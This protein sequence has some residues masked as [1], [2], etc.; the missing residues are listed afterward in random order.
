MSINDQ[1]E[2][3]ISI[4]TIKN[5]NIFGGKDTNNTGSLM[6]GEFLDQEIEIEVKWTNYPFTG[7]MVDFSIVIPFEGSCLK[8]IYQMIDEENKEL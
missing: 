3:K 4:E 6:Q 5:E 7:P 8:D 1:A 2:A